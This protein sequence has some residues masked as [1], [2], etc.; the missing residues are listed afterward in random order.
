MVAN[1]LGYID[2]GRFLPSITSAIIAVSSFAAGQWGGPEVDE[3]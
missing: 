3:P 2:F 1:N